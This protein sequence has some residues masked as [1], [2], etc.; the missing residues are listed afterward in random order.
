MKYQT[1]DEYYLEDE[2]VKLFYEQ[3]KMTFWSISNTEFNSSKC[4]L[5]NTNLASGTIVKKLIQ[6]AIHHPTKT[7]TTDANC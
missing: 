2:K 4:T 1:E 5:K 7:S 6:M 3:F